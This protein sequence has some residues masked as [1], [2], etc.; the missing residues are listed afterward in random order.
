[1]VLETKVSIVIRR[2]IDH[3]K[4]VAYM[5]VSFILF[6]HILLVVLVFCI[7]VYTV[8]CFVCFCLIL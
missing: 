5:A 3:T 8:V 2:N 1:M 7:N 6:F 4:F